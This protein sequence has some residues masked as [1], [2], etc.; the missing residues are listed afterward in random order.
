MD[1]E[2]LF[3]LNDNNEMSGFTEENPDILQQLSSIQDQKVISLIETLEIVFTNVSIANVSEEI[4]R[5]VF[6]NQCY[7]LNVIR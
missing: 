6:E 1:T 3:V 2:R 7:E 5:D 4:L